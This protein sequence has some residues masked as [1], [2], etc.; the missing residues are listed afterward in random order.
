[1]N[2]IVQCDIVGS[3]SSVGEASL[4]TSSADRAYLYVKVSEGRF[5]SIVDDD[6]WTPCVLRRS[7]LQLPG[8]STLRLIL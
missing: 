4:N 2:F 1:M 5:Q 8:Y 3:A 7:L 6:R